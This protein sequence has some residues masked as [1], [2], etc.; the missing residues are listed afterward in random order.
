[1]NQ[2]PDIMS[3]LYGVVADLEKMFPGRH[4]TPDGHMVGSIGE[5]IASHYYG[6]NLHDSSN[7]GCD[8][9]ANGKS[10]EVKITQ[11]NRV[12]IR[13]E[14]EH[15]LVLRLHKDGLFDEVYNGKG[16]RVWAQFDSGNRPDNGQYQISL[17]RLKGIMESV[18]AEERL[19]RIC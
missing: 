12:A 4:Y 7:R 6:V 10:V 19:P 14:P 5:A 15:L 18:P 16:C 17:A 9:T 8:G 3:R 11:G 13:S 2:L 1:M